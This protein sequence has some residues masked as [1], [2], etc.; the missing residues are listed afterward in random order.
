MIRAIIYTIIYRV[1]FLTGLRIMRYPVFI[2]G[3][4]H[5]GTSIMLRVL[6]TH[7]SFYTIGD[8]SRLFYKHDRE[9]LRFLSRWKAELISQHK[10]RILEKTPEH[11]Y[12]LDRIFKIFPGAKIIFM[13]RDGRDVACSHKD[14]NSY[15]FGMATWLDATE[16]IRPFINHNNIKMVKLEDFIACPEAM[17]R[18][19]LD[20]ID[21]NFEHSMLEYHKEPVYYY[22]EKIERPLTVEEGE[23]HRTYRNW[24]INQPLF[25]S[26][27]RWPSEMTE[28]EKDYFKKNAQW[29]LQYWGYENSTDW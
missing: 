21:E 24:Q 12:C 26:T 23:S 22:A 10:K 27:T 25:K 5:S 16:T 4:G 8:E 9:L 7:S 6:G 19:V 28:S 29:C 14:R 1:L 20:F 11:I 3:C 18:D 13:V 15:E 2:M 17:L